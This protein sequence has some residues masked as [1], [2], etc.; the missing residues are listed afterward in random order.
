MSATL[1]YDVSRVVHERFENQLSAHPLYNWLGFTMAH[2]YMGSGKAYWRCYTFALKL[3][4]MIEAAFTVRGLACRW[5]RASDVTVRGGCQI[6]FQKLTYSLGLPMDKI[7]KDEWSLLLSIDKT[8][9]D[10]AAWAAYA[11]WLTE[12]NDERGA[13]VAAW[14]S[15]KAAKVRYGV[16]YTGDGYPGAKAY[17]HAGTVDYVPIHGVPNVFEDVPTDE[18]DDDEPEAE[19]A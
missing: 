9:G 15:S 16:L 17:E 3:P 10:L 18:G 5:S 1:R 11:D 4:K 13:R 8:P 19:V 2:R 6:L 12:H 14:L 7:G